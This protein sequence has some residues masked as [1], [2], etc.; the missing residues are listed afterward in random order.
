MFVFRNNTVERFFPKDYAFSGYD[1]ISFIPDDA[2]G[3]VWFYQAPIKYDAGIVSNEISSYFQKLQYVVSR[4]SPSKEMIVLT[5][6]IL[7]MTP[8]SECDHR[9]AAAVGDYNRDVFELERQKSNVKVIDISGFTRRFPA[10][11]LLDWKYYFISQMGMNPRLSKDFCSWWGKKLEA[12]ALKRKKCLVLDLDNTL[13]GGVLGEDGI[14]GIRIGGDYPGNAFLYF[15]K[16]LLELSGS[17][18]ILAIC[19]KNNEQDVLEAWENNQNI[20]LKKD[21]FAVCRINWRDKASNI[22]EMASELNIGLDSVVFVDDNAGERDLVRTALPEVSVPEFPDKPYDLPVFFRE[23]VDRYFK[24]YQITEE[25]MHKTEQYRANAARSGF[26]LSFDDFES[27]LNGLD[28]HLK[29]ERAVESNIPRI[30]QLTQ[31]TNQFNLTTRRYTETDIRQRIDSGWDIWCVGVS[32]RFGDNGI[33]GCIMVDGQFI[34]SFMLSC[35]VL[36]KGIE[37]AFIKT[38]LLRLKESGRSVVRSQYVPSAKNSQVADFYE[39][40][41][42][43]LETVEDGVKE[44]MLDLC[45]YE[46]DIP[47]YYSIEE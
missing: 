17:G 35:R 41:G 46:V 42:F 7:Y 16:A 3:Y 30:A 9:I 15:Q 45:R 47:A 18:V 25:D 34:D 44:Y 32:D 4:I 21:A 22:A 43:E 6:D 2:E 31:K 24:V 11:E 5:M 39:S 26:R 29:I 38:I 28:I 20:L 14:N 33:T 40:C 27:Y 8:L 36:G 12:L 13:W 37:H 10:A 1:D 19:S 23:L